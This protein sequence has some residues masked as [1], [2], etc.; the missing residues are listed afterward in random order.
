VE[1]PARLVF[2]TARRLRGFEQ[3]ESAGRLRPAL[4][5]S[6]TESCDIVFGSATPQEQRRGPN[7]VLLWSTEDLVLWVATNVAVT[8][9]TNQ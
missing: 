4:R 9:A 6:G 1:R 3:S 8:S 5:R 2:T 7:Q